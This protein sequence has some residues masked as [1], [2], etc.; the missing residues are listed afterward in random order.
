MTK[1]EKFKD[2]TISVIAYTLEKYVTFKLSKP[3][4][5]IQMAFLDSFQF[6]P[7]SLEK[8]VK[9]LQLD[10]FTILEAISRKIVI[11]ICLQ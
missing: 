10:Y 7:T 8:L 6:L 11:W 1:L 4:C 9:N 5:P 2:H 3:I